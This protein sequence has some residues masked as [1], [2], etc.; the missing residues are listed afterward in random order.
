MGL[1]SPWNEMAL[2]F[3]AAAPHRFQYRG[4]GL[5]VLPFGLFWVSGSPIDVQGGVDL[6]LLNVMD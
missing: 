4:I 3:S 5:G 2:S 1:P 6:H